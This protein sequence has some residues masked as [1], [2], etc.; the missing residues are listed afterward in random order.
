ML[1]A[2]EKPKLL[3]QLKAAI[4]VR[5]Y[6]PRTEEAYVGWVRRFIFFHHKRHPAEMA[7]AEIQQFL[8]YLADQLKVSASTQ[9]QAL[10]ALVFLYRN[11]LGAPVGNLELVTRA[12]RPEP[13]PVV[14]TK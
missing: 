6:S 8:I 12:R 13:L 2:Q 3:D 11:V 4:R 7:D 9:N 10:N 1:I 5:H 14:L